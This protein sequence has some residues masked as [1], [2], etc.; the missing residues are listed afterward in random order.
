MSG[1]RSHA[2]FAVI[3][4]A[5]A[6]FRLLRDI[7]VQ[8]V[9]SGDITAISREPG[10]VGETVTVE[11]PRQRATELL[12]I[13]VVDSRPFLTEGNLRHQLK[14]RTLVDTSRSVPLAAGRGAER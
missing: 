4:A 11:V 7:V 14:L 9:E 2:R 8:S 1:R 12:S 10:I 5:E 13:Q 3:P 6:R